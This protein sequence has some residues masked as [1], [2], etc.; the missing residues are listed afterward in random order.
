MANNGFDFVRELLRLGNEE[1]TFSVRGGVP[2]GKRPLCLTFSSHP[3]YH[4][5][6]Q[7]YPDP[8]L[9]GRFSRTLTLPLTSTPII[10]L[11][12]TLPLTIHSLSPRLPLRRS[13]PLISPL[14]ADLAAHDHCWRPALNFSLS[15]Y[16]AYYRSWVTNADEY[17][18]LGSYSWNLQALNATRAR[19]LGFK[20]NWD[21]SGT[22]MPY[23]GLFL[24][25]QVVLAGG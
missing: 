3:Q 7:P 12:L 1:I 9:A 16:P 23:D 5:C 6:T 8:I 2:G 4:N 18:G 22:F 25:Y 21:L 19:G 24:P 15:R 17:E 20:L 14:Q 10:N 13:H 11:I